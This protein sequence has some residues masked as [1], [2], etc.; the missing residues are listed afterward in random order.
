VTT[1]IQPANIDQTLD[2]SVD[3]LSAN[4]VVVSGVDVLGYAQS[5][6]SRANSAYAQANTGGGTTSG[7]SQAK[8]MIFSMVFNTSI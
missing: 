5:A 4:T 2:Y 6:F 1:K 8:T 3:Q 7:T